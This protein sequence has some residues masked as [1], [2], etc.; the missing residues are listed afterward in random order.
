MLGLMLVPGIGGAS[1]WCQPPQVA[2]FQELLT[3]QAAAWNRGDIDGFM[4]FYWKSPQLSFSSGGTT[5]WGWEQTR[6]RY[7]SR[8]P[9]KERMGRLTFSGLELIS[10]GDSAALVLGRWQL[11]RPG[12]QPQGNF[13]LVFRQLDGQWRIVHDHTSLAAN[14]PAEGVEP[15]SN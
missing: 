1:A 5:T 4:E 3:S 2:V 10:L 15:L 14:P 6:D 8:Y 11:A 9:T 7:K 12:D 13:S